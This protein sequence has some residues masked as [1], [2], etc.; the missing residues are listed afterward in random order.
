MY[1]GIYDIFIPTLLHDELKVKSYFVITVI[2]I[3]VF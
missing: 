1:I 3:S 2:C